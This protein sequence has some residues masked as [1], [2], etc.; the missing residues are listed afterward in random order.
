MLTTS[1][2]FKST[3]AS[4]IMTRD[5]VTVF[6]NEKAS[7]AAKTLVDRG[8]SGV[9]VVSSQGTCVGVFSAKDFAKPENGETNDSQVFARMSSPAITVSEHHSLMDVAAIMRSSRI[10]RV[11]VLDD[12]GKVVGILSTLDIADQLVRAME[13]EV[14]S[15]EIAY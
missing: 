9:P 12:R 8:I 3:R 7:V 10:H 6:A 2:Y 4:S 5:V 11:P 1:D 15:E 14:E 13:L